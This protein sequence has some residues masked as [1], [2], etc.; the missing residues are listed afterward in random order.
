MKKTILIG[1]SI[2]A[3]SCGTQKQAASATEKYSIASECPKAGQCFVHVLKDN[4]II[5]TPNSIGK[6]YYDTESKQGS[7]VIKYLYNKKDNPAIQDDSFRE[8]ILIETTNDLTQINSNNI[9]VVYGMFCFCRERAG[10]YEVKNCTAEYKNGQVIII[11][12]Q[13]A[14]GQVT[15]TFTINTK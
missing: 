9:K 13:V 4:T 8:E 1:L 10:Y 7:T 2:L 3:L 15:R 14:E 6:M 5:G 12:P 11:L